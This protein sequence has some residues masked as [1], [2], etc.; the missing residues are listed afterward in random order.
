MLVARYWIFDDLY[1]RNSQNVIEYRESSIEHQPLPATNSQHPVQW[2]LVTRYLLLFTEGWILV[3]RFFCKK[4][5]D[6]LIFPEIKISIKIIY[7]LLSAVYKWI[8]LSGESVG[9]RF[10]IK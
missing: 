8:S 5:S 10:V 6:L 7:A 4:Y 2:L 9:M 3:T 1:I